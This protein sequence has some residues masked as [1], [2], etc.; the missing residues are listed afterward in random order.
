MLT[1]R[2]ADGLRDSGVIVPDAARAGAAHP[3]P[4]FPGG[5]ARRS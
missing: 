3:E 5:H 1:G 2:L 4:A